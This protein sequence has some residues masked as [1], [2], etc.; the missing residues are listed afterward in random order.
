MSNS[1]PPPITAMCASLTNITL[2]PVEAPTFGYWAFRFISPGVNI[3]YRGRFA[4]KSI[5]QQS[6]IQ[7]SD[8]HRNN[9]P[10]IR[11]R[12]GEDLDAW[13]ALCTRVRE[14]RLDTETELTAADLARSDYPGRRTIGLIASS[15]N[16]AWV[17]LWNDRIGTFIVVQ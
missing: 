4:P 14:K 13:R 6:F 16:N 2:K 15:G 9:Y 5:N 7:G 12:N 10:L 8:T 11:V 1:S 3:W 17:V